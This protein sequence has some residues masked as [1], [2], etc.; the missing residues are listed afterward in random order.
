MPNQPTC[1]WQDA[2]ASMQPVHEP[3]GWE[4]E[5][6]M[7]SDPAEGTANTLSHALAQ[8]LTMLPNHVRG[9]EL[10]TPTCLRCH[11][12]F[13][14]PQGESQGDALEWGLLLKPSF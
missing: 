3:P 6:A 11:L 2:V 4:P 5:T 13:S 9:G 10:T 7:P 14:N 12:L 1:S 8:W